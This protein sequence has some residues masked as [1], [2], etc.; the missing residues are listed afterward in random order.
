MPDIPSAARHLP[1][2]LAALTATPAAWA[3][4]IDCHVTYAGTT[5]I[6]AAQ[7]SANPYTVPGQ[8]IGSFFLF[9]VVLRDR[10]GD[11]SGIKIYTY[12][13]LDRG[14]QLIHQATYDID[15]PASVNGGFTGR[16]TVYEPARDAE[17]QYWCEW[18]KP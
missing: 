12:A 4:N 17:L 7:A 15:A 2:L 11:L 14:P 5:Q 9:R 13:N 16:Q 1:W 10:P 8:E 18:R 3:Q 6:I